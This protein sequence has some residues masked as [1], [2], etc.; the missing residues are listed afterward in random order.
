MD[1][2]VALQSASTIWKSP[3]VNEQEWQHR[4]MTGWEVRAACSAFNSA[5]LRIGIWHAPKVTEVHRSDVT[6]TEEEATSGVNLNLK[7][8]E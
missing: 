3:F 6:V 2:A 1:L 7:V 4:R 8:T 5:N